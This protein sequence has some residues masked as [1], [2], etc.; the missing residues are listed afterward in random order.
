MPL[1][2]GQT[3]EGKNAYL[4][5]IPDPR[6]AGGVAES[7]IILALKVVAGGG[8]GGEKAHDEEKCGYGETLI[9]PPFKRGDRLHAGRHLQKHELSMSPRYP[10]TR[11]PS[12]G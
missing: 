6:I 12:K 2:N 9:K 3:N 10:A 7:K 8:G 5:R 1:Q 4:C 11:T